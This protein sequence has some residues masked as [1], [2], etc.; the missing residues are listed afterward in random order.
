MK[1]GNCDDRG[2][3]ADPNIRGA[4]RSCPCGYHNRITEALIVDVTLEDL[5]A[6]RYG[7]N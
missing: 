7:T 1:C 5:L 6:L 4:A 3:I 2:M